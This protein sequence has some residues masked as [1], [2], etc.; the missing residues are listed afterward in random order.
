VQWFRFG[1]RYA[2]QREQAPSPQ[3][4][5]YNDYRLFP[6]NRSNL[7]A[8]PGF[9]GVSPSCQLFHKCWPFI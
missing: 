6:R 7:L 5:P 3:I 1:D 8:S 2:T 9:I 4:L